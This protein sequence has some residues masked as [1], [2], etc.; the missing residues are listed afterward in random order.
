[1][2]YSLSVAPNQTQHGDDRRCR[3]RCIAQVSP[4]RAKG[5]D[6]HVMDIPAQNFSRAC[7]ALTQR[8]RQ[9]L[10]ST[11]PVNLCRKAPSRQP[12]ASMP[13]SSRNLDQAR[14]RQVLNRQLCPNPRGHQWMAVLHRSITRRGDAF[15]VVSRIAARSSSGH[16]L[17][18][19]ARRGRCGNA[20]PVLPQICRQPPPTRANSASANT[21]ETPFVAAAKQGSCRVNPD[22]APHG[23]LDG[24]PFHSDRQRNAQYLIDPPRQLMPAVRDAHTRAHC[25]LCL[26][27]DS[28][29]SWSRSA[30]PFP[31][32][33]AS[34]QAQQPLR[35]LPSPTLP[36]GSIRKQHIGRH[37]PARAPMRPA[38]VHRPTCSGASVIRH[39]CLKPDPGQLALADLNRPGFRKWRPELVSGSPMFRPPADVQGTAV[40]MQARPTRRRSSQIRAFH[41][42]TPCQTATHASASQ[43]RNH[44]HNSSRLV[45]QSRR[46][47]S[48]NWTDPGASFDRDIV[49]K[50]LAPAMLLATF[51]TR[52]TRNI[53]LFETLCPAPLWF[54]C[55]PA[56]AL[57]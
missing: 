6:D 41:V 16:A 36:V 15:G 55:T 1:V 44:M 29:R 25:N 14:Y 17:V 18:M 28:P 52:I 49:T 53:P 3:Q 39:D 30:P 38:G 10:V 20:R 46:D 22:G 4:S 5:R 2:R 35:H 24:P 56:Q 57:Q 45:C 42:A 9:R 48:E 11:R 7:P 51:Q 27:A 37:D 23:P 32:R 21:A 26:V 40:L 34:Q 19:A 43:Q 50:M 8:A 47:P 54:Q 33:S 12:S 13:S 31:L